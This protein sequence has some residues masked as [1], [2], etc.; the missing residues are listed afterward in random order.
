MNIFKRRLERIKDA[1]KLSRFNNSRHLQSELKTE[2]ER[3]E[4]DSDKPVVHGTHQEYF[5]NDDN[6]NYVDDNEDEINAQN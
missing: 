5:A 2:K 4:F 3:S 1:V 6:K